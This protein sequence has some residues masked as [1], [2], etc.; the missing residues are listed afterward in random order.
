MREAVTSADEPAAACRTL[1][2]LA[3]ERGG[4][5]NITVGVLGVSESRAGAL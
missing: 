4:H 2:A 5:D 1:V 3:R